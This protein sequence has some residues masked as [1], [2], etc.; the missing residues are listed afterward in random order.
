MVV[1]LCNCPPDKAADIARTL[2]TEGLCACVNAIPG[3]QSTFV[4]EGKLCEEGE[5]TL[6]I[7]TADTAVDALSA[8]I[9]AIH[10]Y[11]TPEILVLPVDAE[12]SDPAYVAW[13]RGITSSTR[14]APR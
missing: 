7:K 11:T 8:R 13:V 1:V 4:W 2:V 3:V 10:P 9:R 6:L 14:P 12:R 5:T